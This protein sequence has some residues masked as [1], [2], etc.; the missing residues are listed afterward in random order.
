MNNGIHK[1]NKVGANENAKKRMI[2]RRK[3]LEY[4]GIWKKSVEIAWRTYIKMEKSFMK[5][6][7]SIQ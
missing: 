3:N 1:E 2:K 5:S 6:N 4:N 7:K